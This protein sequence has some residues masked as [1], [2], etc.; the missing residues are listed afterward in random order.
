MKETE[1]NRRKTIVYLL[2]TF[3]V[4]YAMQIGV[5]YLYKSGSS[6]SQALM[7]VMMFVP[8]FGVLVTGNTLKNMGWKPVFKGNG[9]VIMFAWFGPAIITAV[10]AMIYFMIFPQHFDLSGSYVIEAV[11]EDALQQMLA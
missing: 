7:A 5:Y 2:F 3:V 10:G 4:A 9:K 6:L 1:Y 8:F 11:G